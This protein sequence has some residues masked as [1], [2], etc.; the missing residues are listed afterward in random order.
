M[1]HQPVMEKFESACNKIMK[2][3][4]R[5]RFV[6]VVSGNGKPIASSTRRGV[7]PFVDK[8]GGEITLTQAVLIMR[9][10]REFDEELGRV[11]YV[12]IKREKIAMLMFSF[13]EDL[14]YVSCDLGC[15]MG[16]LAGKI[17]QV[18]A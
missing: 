3:N 14:L 13:G 1:Y 8:K 2:L 9:M 17:L 4:P 12:M 15:D 16:R 6:A 7:E 5:V 11:N 18:A 10:H